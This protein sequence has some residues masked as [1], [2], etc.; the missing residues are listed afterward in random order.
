[1][2][3]FES[4]KWTGVAIVFLIVAVTAIYAMTTW[5]GGKDNYGNSSPGSSQSTAQD[6]VGS[7]LQAQP[8]NQNLSGG[9]NSTQLQQGAATQQSAQPTG[10]DVR[11]PIDPVGCH[12]KYPVDDSRMMC[13]MP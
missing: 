4:S 8:T 13:L 9:A 7:G 10:D 3:K 6:A 1:M 2:K 11:Y 12:G 5:G